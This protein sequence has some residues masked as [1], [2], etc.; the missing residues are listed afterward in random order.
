MEPTP[1]KKSPA[2]K[3][4]TKKKLP[5]YNYNQLTIEDV[6]QLGKYFVAELQ[7]IEKAA[8]GLVPEISKLF[9]S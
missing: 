7:K 1:Q 9:K 2:K 3:T 5:N 8:P 4:T 6:K